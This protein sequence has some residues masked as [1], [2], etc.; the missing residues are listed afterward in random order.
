MEMKIDFSNTKD[1]E[2]AL[3]LNWPFGYEIFSL[4]GLKLALLTCQEDMIIEIFHSF[5]AQKAL[6]PFCDLLEEI[7]QK[8]ENIYVIW[9]AV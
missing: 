8:K 4:E 5:D 6:K 2:S 1:V 7:Q 9:G 3:A